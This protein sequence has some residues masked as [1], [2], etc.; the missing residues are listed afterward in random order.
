MSP[1]RGVLSFDNPLPAS[2]KP[3]KSNR[4][5]E[6]PAAEMAVVKEKAKPAG[7]PSVKEN[8][9]SFIGARVSDE[10]RKQL[11]I[12]AAQQD[13]T[14]QDLIIE[15]MNDLFVKYKLSRIA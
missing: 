14:S 3:S 4:G 13:K 12:L 7:E 8:D 9:L 11:R 5:K 10:A 6:A 1:K 2:P 15:A